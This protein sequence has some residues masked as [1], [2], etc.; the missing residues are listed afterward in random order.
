MSAFPEIDM[1][2]A[3]FSTISNIITK[4]SSGSDSDSD[5][6]DSENKKNQEQK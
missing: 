1:F 6:D 2:D 3:V 5:S 4:K